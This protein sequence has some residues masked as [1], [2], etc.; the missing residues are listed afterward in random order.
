MN[1]YLIIVLLT[2]VGLIPAG[3]AM[4]YYGDGETSAGNEL[5]ATTLD[6]SL[7]DLSGVVLTGLL[8]DVAG[9]VP[10][11]EETESLR[12]QN[13]G[14]LDATYGAWS[15]Q[16]GGN[17]ALCDALQLGATL[18]GTPV[19]GSSLTGFNESPAGDILSGAFD[20][21]EFTVGLDDDDTSLREKTCEFDL[22][23]KGW[24]QDSD[25][26]WG[27]TDEERVGSSVVTGNWGAQPGDVVINEVMWMGSTESPYDEWIELRNMTDQEI[28]IGQWTIDNGRSGGQSLVMTPASHTIPAD[29][30]LLI[31]NN[32]ETSAN[33]A[34]N[35]PVDVVNASLSLA[36]E[37]NGN[38]VLRD[39]GGNA[40]D[41]AKGDSWPAGAHDGLE[42]SMERNNVPGDGTLA[43]S[44]HTCLDAGCNDGTF[45]DTADGDNYGTP[46]AANLSENDLTSGDA[47][48]VEEG[49][50]AEGGE[51]LAGEGD[52]AVDP[53][54][55][56]TGMGAEQEGPPS[57]EAT[58][59]KGEDEEVAWLGDEGDDVADIGVTGEGDDDEDENDGDADG[60]N[61]EGDSGS[62][63][64]ES[65]E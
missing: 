2:V 26:T 54:V 19:Y 29:G 7:R 21:W 6:L 39:A 65:D 4:A 62:G 13:D 52:D 10:G 8:F 31:A 58:G 49:M 53:A 46:K 25:G 16:T 45:W 9:M 12:V 55:E 20:G 27:F 59:G 34:L 37:D 60:E 40:I 1:R 57:P 14:V 50:E 56:P 41:E 18:E 22:V 42:Q 30:F 61:G 11:D 64:T 28:D 63:E 3:G 44:W 47:V 33:S 24:Q 48:D 36:N 15:V 51:E 23:F 17:T 32:P 43:E 38:L 35:V 5:G